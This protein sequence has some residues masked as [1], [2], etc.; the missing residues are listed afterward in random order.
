MKPF[1]SNIHNK[2]P[3]LTR[4]LSS[5]NAKS[6]VSNK[7]GESSSSNEKCEKN[8]L[9]EIRLKIDNPEY[10]GTRNKKRSSPY[11]K[12]E[13]LS[14]SESDSECNSELDN[15]ED[16]VRK[17]IVITAA[18]INKTKR[19]YKTLKK[20]IKQDKSKQD[21]SQQSKFNFISD[22]LGIKLGAG[23]LAPG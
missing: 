14:S 21:K 9:D 11:R 8:V 3:N 4:K 5:Q 2:S 12:N 18:N 7:V 16:N 13:D 19:N 20:I 1:C 15:R 23:F 6:P 22:E 10:S 17:C